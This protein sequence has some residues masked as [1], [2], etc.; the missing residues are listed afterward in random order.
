MGTDVES[1][2]KNNRRVFCH[3]RSAVIFAIFK[4]RSLLI[5]KGWAGAQLISFGS[6]WVYLV[7]ILTGIPCFKMLAAEKASL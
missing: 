2:L 6:D 7:V 5:C 3:C 4:I 1:W